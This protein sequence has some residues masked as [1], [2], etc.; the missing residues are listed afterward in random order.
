M[1]EVFV[2]RN[3][4]ELTVS[5]PQTPLEAGDWVVWH[6]PPLNPQELTFIHFHSLEHPFGPF[7]YLEPSSVH[8]RGLGN[9]GLP[10]EYHYT[11]FILNEQ[12]VAARS[13]GSASIV[14]LSATEDTSPDATLHYD[15]Q[16]FLHE[17]PTLKV[18]VGRTA[19][20]YITGV[21][22]DHFVTFLFDGFEDAMVGPFSS[23]AISRGFGDAWVATGTDFTGQV[24]NTE[25]VQIRIQYHVR[26]HR[27]DGTVLAGGDPVIE[28]PGWPPGSPTLP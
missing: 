20:W 4:T 16:T 18:E 23:F 24:P 28:P 8:V 19:L 2:T 10:G 26:L 12:G 25:P 7:Q 5:N 17:P 21:P 6:F 3:G 14:N 15:G 13:H 9:S 1:P 11:A 22:A 27:P